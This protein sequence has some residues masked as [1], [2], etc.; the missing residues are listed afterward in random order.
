MVLLIRIKSKEE[1][2]NMERMWMSLVLEILSL[3]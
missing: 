2:A 1:G 3:R